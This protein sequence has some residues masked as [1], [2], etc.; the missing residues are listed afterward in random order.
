MVIP[1]PPSPAPASSPV[2]VVIPTYN[3][4]ELL[5]AALLSVLAQTVPAREI[6][7]ADDESPDHTRDVVREL[8]AG[9]APIV[10]LPGGGRDS[11]APGHNRRSAARNR[12]VAATT[13]PLVAFLD[14]DDIWQP[15]RLE[16]QLD[17]LA[18]APGAG[19]A[20]CN[21]QR[22]DSGGLHDLRPYLPPAADY[23]GAILGALLEE[24]LVASSTLLVRRAALDRVGGWADVRKGEDY[25]LSLRLAAAYPASYVP[26]VL[27]LLREHTGR[28]SRAQREMPLVDTVAILERFLAT[29]RDLP[30]AM[31]AR[32]RRG[33]ANVH[34][35]LAR[36]YWQHGEPATARRHLRALLRLRP[37]ERRALLAYLRSWRAAPAPGPS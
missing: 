9:G 8:A 13:A 1:R 28:T 37:W 4:A 17:A 7:V 11:P 18:R 29:H 5:R 6:V 25:E 15:G 16:R 22:F 30:P 23:N 35:K 36:L 21:L 24:A 3:R 34:F 12:G 27:V 19:F 14:S 2:S 31:R 33:L 26:E 20:F 10:Y 32:G